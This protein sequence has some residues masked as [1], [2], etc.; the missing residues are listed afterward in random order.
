M[1]RPL[2]SRIWYYRPFSWS[3]GLRF[4]QRGG[5]EFDWHTIVVGSRLTGAV[6]FATRPCDYTGDCAGLLELYEEF[7]TIKP[8]WPVDAHGHKHIGPCSCETC[9]DDPNWNC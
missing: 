8:K 2:K 1:R 4:I 7:G 5:D 6:I 9:L 3:P